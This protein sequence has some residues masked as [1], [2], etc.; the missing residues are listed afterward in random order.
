MSQQKIKAESEEQFLY[1][2]Q[3]TN[4]NNVVKNKTKDVIRYIKTLRTQTC[5][6]EKM[7]EFNRLINHALSKTTANA[8]L[9]AIGYRYKKQPKIYDWIENKKDLQEEKDV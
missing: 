6:E 2:M 4:L 7:I 9:E 8:M 5:Y 1:R 3:T